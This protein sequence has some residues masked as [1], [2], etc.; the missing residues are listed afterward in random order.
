MRITQGLI[1]LLLACLT[2][3]T[4]H[5]Q[6]RGGG[7]LAT[8]AIIVSDPAGAPLGGVNVTLTGPTSRQARTERGR[9]AFEELPAGLYRLRFEREGFVTLEREVTARGGAPMDIKVA[10]TAAPPPPKPAPAP[11]PPPPPPNV[12]ADPVTLNVTSFLEKNFI[13]RA[14]EK[15]SRLA[16]S[17]S[18]TATLIQ[19]R[20]PLAE[21]THANVDEYLYVIAGAGIA[22]VGGSDQSL[23]AGVFLMVPRGVPHAL[24]SGGRNPLIVLSITAGE[25]CSESH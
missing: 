9:I 15:M 23:Q 1:I 12:K 17:G 5:A 13:G 11:E 10:L 14:P 22:R 16:C 18:G 20:D 24:A 2:A 6:R 19:L 4:P 3:S 21:H 7:G 25:P 8:L